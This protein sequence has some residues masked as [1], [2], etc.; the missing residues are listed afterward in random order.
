ML[1]VAAWLENKFAAPPH[2][3]E[4]AGLGIREA[5]H[6][7]RDLGYSKRE[8]KIYISNHKRRLRLAEVGAD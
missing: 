1:N 5:E 3:D 7:L 8:A 2:A 4:L 6:R